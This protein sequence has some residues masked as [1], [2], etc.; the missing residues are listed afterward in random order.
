[1]PVHRCSKGGKK[2]YQWGKQKCYTGKGARGKAVRQGQAVR[3]N[4]SRGR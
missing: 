3:A 2:G 1:M 4:Q